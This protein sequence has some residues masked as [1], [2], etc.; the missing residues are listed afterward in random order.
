MKAWK[1]VFLA[2]FK[3]NRA[4]VDILKSENKGNM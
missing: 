2:N 4:G 3:H 1:K